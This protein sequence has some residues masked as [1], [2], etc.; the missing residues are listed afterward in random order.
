MRRFNEDENGN[1]WVWEKG[2][3]RYI[4]HDPGPKTEANRRRNLRKK[5][6]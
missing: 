2:R 6:K 5:S 4:D 3:R 1:L